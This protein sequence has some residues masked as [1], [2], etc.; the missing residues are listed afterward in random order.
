M[1]SYSYK[2]VVY[3]S[4]Q[5]DGVSAVMVYTRGA[6][7]TATAGRYKARHVLRTHRIVPPLEDR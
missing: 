7:F 6:M 5:L 4:G 3:S 2:V 1:V